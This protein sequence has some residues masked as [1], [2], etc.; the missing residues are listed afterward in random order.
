MHRVLA[1]SSYICEVATWLKSF[2]LLHVSASFRATSFQGLG[3]Q[4]LA[5][6]SVFL[7]PVISHSQ[8]RCAVPGAV[9]ISAT[10]L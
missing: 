8:V 6:P 3:G 4:T 1:N 5:G 2:S 7:V 10:C 9:T